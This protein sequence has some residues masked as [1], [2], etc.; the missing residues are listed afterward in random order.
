MAR[1]LRLQYHKIDVA[2]G[3]YGDNPRGMTDKINSLDI[4][5]MAESLRTDV[6][7]PIHHDIWTNFMADPKEILVLWNMRKNRLQYKFTPFIWEVGG[8]FTYPDDRLRIEYH[9]PRGFD[10]AFAIEPDLPFKSLL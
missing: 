7:I 5:R 10:D 4:L 6:I 2:L 9:H 3:S 1:T 8:K